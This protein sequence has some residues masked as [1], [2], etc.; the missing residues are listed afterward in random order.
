MFVDEADGDAADHRFELSAKLMGTG[1][2][3][4]DDP[5]DAVES[6]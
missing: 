1:P 3:T 2:V 5:I 4:E 6:I